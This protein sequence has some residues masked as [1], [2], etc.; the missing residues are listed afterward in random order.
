MQ[1]QEAVLPYGRG[2]NVRQWQNRLRHFISCGKRKSSVAE[3]ATAPGK[4]EKKM[5]IHSNTQRTMKPFTTYSKLYLTEGS[6]SNNLIR[7]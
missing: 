3:A 6:G 7:F 2:T 1:A 5:H 4:E